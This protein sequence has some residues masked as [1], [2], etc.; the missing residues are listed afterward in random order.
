MKL[1]HI[2][3]RPENFEASLE[4][5]EQTIGLKKIAS[6]GNRPNERGA[7][8]ES[9]N[10][11]KI[12]I[13]DEIEGEDHDGAVIGRPSL[14]IE[15]SDFNEACKKLQGSNMVVPPEINQWGNK[16]MI[17]RDPDQNLIG[18]V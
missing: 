4:F 11:I 7:I 14:L 17:I 16:W 5:Y 1:G 13:T 18:L 3:I 10:G 6:W 15:V 12:I 2:L 8:L 9:V